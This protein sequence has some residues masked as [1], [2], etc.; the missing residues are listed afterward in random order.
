MFILGSFLM[1]SLNL[2]NN[3]PLCKCSTR[4]PLDLGFLKFEQFQY[5]DY[6]CR[7]GYQDHHLFFTQIDV[8]F[9]GKSEYNIRN[10][11]LVTNFWGIAMINGFGSYYFS[12]NIFRNQNLL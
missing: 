5:V 2:I 11:C 4:Y 8:F 6:L 12:K 3:N 7:L 1:Q 10:G 9:D